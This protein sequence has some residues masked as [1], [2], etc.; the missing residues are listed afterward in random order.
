M[1][2]PSPN[3]SISSA[4]D[5]AQQ[6]ARFRTKSASYQTDSGGV[7]SKHMWHPRTFFSQSIAVYFRS[8]YLYITRAWECQQAPE[9]LWRDHGI[10][11]GTCD[12]ASR[13]IFPVFAFGFPFQ[14]QVTGE[15]TSVSVLRIGQRSGLGDDRCHEIF[16]CRVGVFANLVPFE[17]E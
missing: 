1:L 15:V 5:S 9:P 11:C 7:Q 3:H 8:L 10:V 4:P 2:S 6:S 14:H 12:T 16:V 17:I 13:R